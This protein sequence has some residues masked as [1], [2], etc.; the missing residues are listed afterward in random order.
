MSRPLL[1]VSRA[2]RTARLTSRRFAT[3]TDSS[4]YAE[5]QAIKEHAQHTKELWRKISFYG[6]VPATLVC[7]AWVRNV[8]AEHEAHVEHVK[9]VNGGE[10]PRAPEYE[11]LNRRAKPFPWG[12]NTLFY[13]SH[14]NKDMSLPSDE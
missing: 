3:A 13:N 11:Y 6:C 2:T 9:E 12:Y 1:A 8:E 10:V 4:Y 14:V 7:I 5:K